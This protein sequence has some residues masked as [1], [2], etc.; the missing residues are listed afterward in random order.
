MMAQNKHVPALRFPEFNG[1][2]K[3]MRLGEIGKFNSGTG[4]PEIA[5]GGKIGIPFYKVSDMNLKGN[6]FEMKVSNNYV[7]E[8]QINTYKYKPIKQPSIIFAKVG[9]AIF[10]E[11]K[12][13]AKNF[14]IDNNMMS[15]T[16]TDNILFLKYLFE[17]LRLSKFAQVGALPSYNS[18]DIGIIKIKL[19]SKPEQQKIAAFLTSIE[20]KIQQL[21]K[22]KDLLEQFKKGV[23]QKIFNQEIR[24]KADNGS[25]F[26][27]WEEKKIEPF[28]KLY[29]ERVNAD[30]DIPILTSS[31]NG[32]FFQKDYF[33]D[34]ELDNEGEYGVV[35][36]GY[37]TYRH[38]SDDSTF[39]FN[40]NNIC[41]KGAVS[42][43]Y[44]VFTTQ[45][46]DAT[47]LQLKLNFGDEFKRFAIEQ[48]RGGTRTRLYFN[49]L[50]QLIISMPSLP[51]QQKITT[52]LTAFDKKIHLVNQ[53]LE[54]TKEF[55][56]GL[57][58]QIF[59]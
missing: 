29:V 43:E 31:R 17:T 56:K 4:F 28:L 52:F 1:D 49:K 26:A 2:W 11:R 55:K 37:F 39:K 34:R 45:E 24:F 58:Q 14:L 35:P 47:F 27:D 21:T 3:E 30:T 25:D 15:F 57:L 51:E 19:P 10:L 5:Q 48:K 16:P 44:P 23:M 22:K 13:I 12:R 9:A 53:Q 32:L 38:M 59:V 54:K 41:D 46:M 7:T 8:E 6:E 33:D 42:K 20:G 18:S 50:T 36:R 40:I